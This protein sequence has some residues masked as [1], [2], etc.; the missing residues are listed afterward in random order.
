MLY[1]VFLHEMA[2]EPPTGGVGHESVARYLPWATPF[3]FGAGKGVQWVSPT[4]GLSVTVTRM[5]SRGATLSFATSSVGGLTDTMGPAW[6]ASAPKVRRGSTPGS[7]SLKLG[8][9]WDQSGVAEAT[10][11]AGGISR[12]LPMPTAGY[13]VVELPITVERGMRVA[14]TLTLTDGAGNTTTWTRRLRG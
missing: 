13:S 9:A 7:Y 1:G 6:L 14:L 3:A 12:A 10:L 2:D 5:S 4:G 8:A 11:T